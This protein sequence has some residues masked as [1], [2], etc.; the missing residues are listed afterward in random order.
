MKSET[1]D[2]IVIAF[3]VIIAIPCAAI[4]YKIAFDTVFGKSKKDSQN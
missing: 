1:V 3:F 4:M 2:Q